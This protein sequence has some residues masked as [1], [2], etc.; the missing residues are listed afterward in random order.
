[1]RL[2]N[3]VI[4]VTASTR[5][6]GWAIVQACAK[7]GAIVYMAVRRVEDAR[8]QVK[9]LNEQGRII[10]AIYCDAYDHQTY[11]DMIETI[12]EEEGRLDVL[13]NNFGTSDPRKDKDIEQ[14]D[15]HDFISTIDTNLTSV[16]IP[17]Q[18]AIRAMKGNGCGS[19]INISSIGGVVPDIS[20]VAYGTSKA[21]I[22]YLT[23]LIAVQAAKY[24]IRCNAICPGMIATD[25]VKDNLSD[26]F[27]TFF[28]KHIPLNRM[29]NPD[30]IAALAV[31]FA[32]DESAY[33]T[34]QVVEV[35]GGFGIPTP[36]F[37]DLTGGDTKR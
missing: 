9:E 7:E 30:E 10:K 21:G 36:V 18:E 6:I 14:T 19:L 28:L 3:K 33:T 20:Q 34:G 2:K 32:S 11:K 35:A 26:E 12:V 4:A 5:G 13:V 27:K 23:K 31:Y 37:G 15:F 29:G 24:N 1:M 8:R 25:A 22:N 16:Y 17:C